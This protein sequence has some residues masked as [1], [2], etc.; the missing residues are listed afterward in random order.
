MADNSNSFFDQAPEGRRSVWY[1]LSGSVMAVVLFALLNAAVLSLLF[2][3][4]VRPAFE[5]ISEQKNWVDLTPDQDLAALIACTFILISVIALL[6]A[7]LIVAKYLHRQPLVTLLTARASFDM[8][9]FLQSGFIILA[10]EG[11]FLLVSYALDPDSFEVVFDFA[12]MWPFIFVVV[13]LTPF[14]ALAEEAFFRGYLTQGVAALTG[15][16]GIRLVVPAIF[17]TIFHAFNADWSAGGLWAVLTYF[18]MALYLAVLALKTNGLEASTGM[19]AFHNMFVFLVATSTSSG[20]PFATV[21][22]TKG[23]QTDYMMGYLFL[24]PVLALHYWAS[25]KAGLLRADVGN[26]APAS[27]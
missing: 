3:P 24:F 9:R 8:R 6:V 20:M 12:R 1:Y 27:A 22:V 17:F 13:L 5:L 21:L 2:I 4:S 10:I 26:G 15:I 11:V 23:E 25:Q 18:T 16:L 7:T 19:H 14:Q